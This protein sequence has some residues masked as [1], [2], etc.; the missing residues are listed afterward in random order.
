ML[1]KK[2]KLSEQVEIGGKN[3]YELEWGLFSWL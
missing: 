1:H 3:F 2:K